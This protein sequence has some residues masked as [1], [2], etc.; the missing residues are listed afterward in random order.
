MIGSS[1]GKMI[2]NSGKRP[3]GVIV[4]LTRPMEG[5]R[6]GGHSDFKFFGELSFPQHSAGVV[7]TLNCRAFLYHSG[8]LNTMIFIFGP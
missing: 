5:N 6:G 8:I 7:G 3:C 1:D 2:V 4:C